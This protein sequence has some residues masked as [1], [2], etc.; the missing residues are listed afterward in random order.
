MNTRTSRF[1][2]VSALAALPLVAGTAVLQARRGLTPSDMFLY[3]VGIGMAAK[4]LGDL[5]YYLISPARRRWLYLDRYV[6][7]DFLVHSRFIVPLACAQAWVANKGWLLL[8][9]LWPL[10]RP[11][12]V[13]PGLALLVW[14]INRYQVELAEEARHRP[15]GV[16][17]AG[18]TPAGTPPKP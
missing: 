16:G 6:L 10:L 3:F 18:I 5:W 2:A 11:V 1:L 15:L 8:P 13:S 9:T 7:D 12:W 14:A 4:G 17:A